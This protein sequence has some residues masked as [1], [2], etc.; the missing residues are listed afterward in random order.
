MSQ[1]LNVFVEHLYQQELHEEQSLECQNGGYENACDIYFS[2]TVNFF[3]ISLLFVQQPVFMINEDRT[4]LCL[5]LCIWLFFQQP[6]FVSQM[7]Q[8]ERVDIITITQVS[9]L[10]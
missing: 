8:L 5:F 7:N 1:T 9:E 3:L 4:S 10:C 2:V 6:V